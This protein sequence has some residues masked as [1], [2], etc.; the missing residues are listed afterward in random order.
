MYSHSWVGSNFKFRQ[1]FSR[2][3]VT[4]LFYTERRSN[5]LKAKRFNPFTDNIVVKAAKLKKDLTT[6]K[7]IYN[8]VN[9]R[10]TETDIKEYFIFVENLAAGKFESAVDEYLLNREGSVENII[11]SA[12]A[13]ERC[14]KLSKIDMASFSN[15]F[16]NS[17]VYT[18]IP[19]YDTFNINNIN[20]IKEFFY[21][22]SNMEKNKTEQL[23]SA[24]PEKGLT[25]AYRSSSDVSSKNFFP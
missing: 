22:Y 8:V 10:M 1:L 9:S 23:T 20:T 18:F 16:N 4:P 2:K 6:H 15:E 11:E 5:F 17:I 12:K 25:P 13:L 3:S 19:D 21:F 14:F 7:E 24:L